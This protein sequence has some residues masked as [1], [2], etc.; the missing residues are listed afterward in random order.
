MSSAESAEPGVLDDLEAL[1]ASTRVDLR[2]TSVPLIVFGL[3]LLLAAMLPEATFELPWSAYWAVA[4][5]LG[6][7]FVA[8]WYRRIER[9]VGI[10]D[11][12]RHYAAGAIGTALLIAMAASVFIFF[13]SPLAGAGVSL[14]V[15]ARASRGRWIGAVG[16]VLL[17]L[18]LLEPWFIL[19]NRVFEIAQLFGHPDGSEA[20]FRY[21][22]NV[23]AGV[24]AA[25]VLAAGIIARL[26]GR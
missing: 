17:V 8:Y 3:L 15:V 9:E 24:I 14:L 7:A 5:P 11:L 20:I 16:G 2:P 10:G 4:G 26:Q 6:F 22:R 21:S 19:S 12:S 1:R 18:G 23:I 13:V 25:G